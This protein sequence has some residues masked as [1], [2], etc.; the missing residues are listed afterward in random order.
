MLF[1]LI[2]I[3]IIINVIINCNL[4]V[5]KIRVIFMGLL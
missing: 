1:V 3:N 4:P 5:A 2:I